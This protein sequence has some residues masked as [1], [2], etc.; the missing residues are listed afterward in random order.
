MN[1]PEKTL[2]D[3]KKSPPGKRFQTLYRKRQQ[4]RRG[5]LK[6][7]A[8]II[9][10][11]MV[12]AAG[13]LTYPIPVTPSELMILMGIALI[14]QGSRHG[15][16]VLD[17]IERRLRRRFSGVLKVWKGLPRSAKVFLAALWMAFT[18]AMG[19]FVYRLIFEA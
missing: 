1:A 13:V 7:A 4:S 12:I 5:G 9:A 6:N 2:R 14:A 17:W 18:S 10:G 15:A 16:I 8:F 3:L 11:I 19:Y